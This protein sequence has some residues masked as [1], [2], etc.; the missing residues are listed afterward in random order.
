MWLTIK[1]SSIC[2]N[3][4][5]TPHPPSPLQ[6][7]VLS[8]N[9]TSVIF[10]QKCDLQSSTPASV[11]TTIS[12]PPPPP[13]PPPKFCFIWKFYFSDFYAKMWLTIKYSSICDNHYII[14]C[15]KG[16]CYILLL[17]FFNQHL[18]NLKYQYTLTCLSI[19]TPKAINF[20]LSQMKN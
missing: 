9:F 12:P 8:G 10:M 1:Y 6:N 5:I 4:N 3:H 18:G 16:K 13:L 15:K 17:C 19:G 2:D 14:I 11:T 7:F 20:P